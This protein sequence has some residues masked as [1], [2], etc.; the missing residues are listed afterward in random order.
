MVTE[1]SKKTIQKTASATT[2]SASGRSTAP[3][4]AQH[5]TVT[6]HSDQARA[7][8][9]RACSFT[10]WSSLPSGWAWAMLVVSGTGS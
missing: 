6:S 8:L 2:A 10:V 3:K 1:P 5:P 9:V 4:A 7:I